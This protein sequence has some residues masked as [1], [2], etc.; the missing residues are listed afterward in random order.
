[1]H[2]RTQYLH[3]RMISMASC[4]QSK[5]LFCAQVLDEFSSRRTQ[6]SEVLC[7]LDMQLVDEVGEYLSVKGIRDW[8]LGVAHLKALCTF[9]RVF[10]GF[11]LSTFL[12]VER[13][14]K[15]TVKW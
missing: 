14:Q 1:M 12:H 2:Y 4:S 10:F 8:S 5:R 7:P 11:F 3:E 6:L 9:F 15:L 13:I